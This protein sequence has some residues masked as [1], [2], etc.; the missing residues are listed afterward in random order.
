VLETKKD[1]RFLKEVEIGCVN[2]INDLDVVLDGRI[3]ACTELID[4]GSPSRK[5]RSAFSCK[6][7]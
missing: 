3:C 2:R 1:A 6:L 4:M 7:R 5:A